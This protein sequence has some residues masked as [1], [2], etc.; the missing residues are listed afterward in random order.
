MFLVSI[1]NFGGGSGGLGLVSGFV[2]PPDGTA[3]SSIGFR[4]FSKR[5]MEVKIAHAVV[6]AAMI[7]QIRCM[8]EITWILVDMLDEPKFMIE[9]WCK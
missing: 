6:T 5:W 4:W 9:M 7:I 3:V 2:Y 8:S 1:L